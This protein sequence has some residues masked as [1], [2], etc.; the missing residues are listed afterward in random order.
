M[1]KWKLVLA[2]SC[3]IVMMLAFPGLYDSKTMREA[4]HHYRE[5][6]SEQTRQELQA[7]R[8]SDRWHVL[9]FELAF[10][11]VLAGLSWALLRRE[12]YSA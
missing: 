5:T 1:K 8:V 9:M 3:L 7:A 10:G 6:P 2:I 11:G 4:H 12:K